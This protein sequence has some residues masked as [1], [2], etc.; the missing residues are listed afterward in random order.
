MKQVSIPHSDL[1]ISKAVFGTSRL[2]GT[3]ERYDKRRRL[4]TATACGRFRQC[5]L[6]TNRTTP[7][8]LNHRIEAC[9]SSLPT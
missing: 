8:L 2:G 1:E 7:I 9:H 5:S 6:A 3:V 4:W